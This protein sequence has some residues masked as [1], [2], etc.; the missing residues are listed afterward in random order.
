MPGSLKYAKA[1]LFWQE[2]S[3]SKGNYEDS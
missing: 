2:P 3:Y 1:S